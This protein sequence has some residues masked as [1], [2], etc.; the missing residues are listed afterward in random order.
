MGWGLIAAVVAGVVST[1][2]VGS[3]A[4]LSKG[5]AQ[6]MTAGLVILFVNAIGL[7]AWGAWKGGLSWPE[8]G[9]ISELP[10]W[11]WIGGVGGATIMLAQLFLAKEMG[12]GAFLAITVTA[13]TITSIAMDHYGLVGF[14]RQA[15]QWDR[16]LGGALMVG[17][18]IL[19]ARNGGS[20]GQA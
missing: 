6:P 18:V 8:Q 5:L 17:G 14:D 1:A 16:L 9:T 7:I 20:W 4:T 3:N 13:G 10:W 11:A 12:A 19:I 2:L 15:A